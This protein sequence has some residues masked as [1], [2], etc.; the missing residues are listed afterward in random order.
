MEIMSAIK[1]QITKRF[2]HETE[3]NRNKIRLDEKIKP[4]SL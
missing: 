3:I 1:V 4:F 2:V